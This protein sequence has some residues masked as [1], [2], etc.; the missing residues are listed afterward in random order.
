[1]K[2]YYHPE[3]EAVATCLECG[4]GLCS[5]CASKYNDI[6]CDDC[7]TRHKTQIRSASWRD[8]IISIVLFAISFFAS[9]FTNQ[10][11]V[12]A[13]FSGWILCGIPFGWRALSWLTSQVFMFMSFFGWIIYLVVKVILSI[14]VGL[15]AMPISIGRAIIKIN[16]NK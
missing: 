12:M 8:I 15:V 11:V 9:L 14:F 6:V 2:C 5:H 7:V 3:I 13:L 10:G 1:M 16:Q 4:R